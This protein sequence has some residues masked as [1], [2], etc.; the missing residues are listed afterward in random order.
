M[1]SVTCSNCGQLRS[2]AGSCSHCGH[3]ATSES[4]GRHAE[5][6][7]RAA[8]RVAII[9]TEGS[10][11][12]VLITVLAK[13]FGRVSEDGFFLNPLDG[14]SIRYVENGWHALDSGEW[15]AGSPLGQLFE[16]QWELHCGVESQ[17]CQ[18][19]LADSAGQDLRRIF[20]DDEADTDPQ[21]PSYLQRLSAYCRN[22]DIV[23]CLVNLKDFLGEGD[24]QRR[25]ESQLVIKGAL[26]RLSAPDGRH[27]RF[28]LLFT[29]IDQY[30]AVYRKYG[31]WAAVAKEHLPYV[32]RAHVA[33]G[34]VKVGAVAAVYDTQV[35]VGSDGTPRR[36]PVPGFTS[37]GLEKVMHWLATET[38]RIA[39][40]RTSEVPRCN[41]RDPDQ[42]KAAPLQENASDD[43]RSFES[44]PAQL[45]QWLV[46]ATVLS[47]KYVA[48]GLMSL[49]GMKL[50][51]AWSSPSAPPR[52]LELTPATAWNSDIEYGFAFD[53]IRITNASR[54]TLR[55]VV[56]TIE[57]F[58]DGRFHGA[59]TLRREVFSPGETH[60]LPNA[61][62]IRKGSGECRIQSATH[63]PI[64][65]TCGVVY[66][67]WRSDVWFANDSPS[68]VR[69]VE[70]KIDVG[71]GRSGRS[72]V[73]QRLNFGPRRLS[74]EGFRLRR[75]S[76]SRQL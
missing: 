42:S 1:P 34:Q 63:A 48:I 53:D 67:R 45:K 11:K 27:R 24:Y 17:A 44:L 74:Q 60:T 54:I 39:E 56:L 28:C 64:L 49:L 3:P 66:G 57:V 58:S 12:T 30:Q 38:K 29:Q 46:K 71:S 8:P 23:I 26:Q 41:A 6:D 75:K 73:F 36:V 5:P 52:L 59:E 37:R 9:G 2:L 10:G 20:S 55:N 32:H 25:T 4:V 69:N 31:D 72:F 76:L 70:V 22:A 14:K 33:T 35:V 50:Y 47:R 40:A 19:R 13:R 43:Q 18:L 61:I 65:A 16:L 68:T 7:S 62:S 15:P 51:S 21:M